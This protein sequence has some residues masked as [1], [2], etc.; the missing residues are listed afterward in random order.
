[1]NSNSRTRKGAAVLFLYAEPKDFRVGCEF[2]VNVALKAAEDLRRSLKIDE[3]RRVT[4]LEA[5]D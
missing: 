2:Y 1:V 3:E 4:R 5:G